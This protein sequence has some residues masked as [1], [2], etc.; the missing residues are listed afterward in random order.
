[1]SEQDVTRMTRAELND[2]AGGLGIADAAE[3][4]NKD[5]VMAAIDA[6]LAEHD[7]APDDGADDNNTDAESD[8][9]ADAAEPE[10]SGTR[11][12]VLKAVTDDDGRTYMPGEEFAPG[13]GFP[14]RRP[15]QL[16]DQKFL[17]PL[18]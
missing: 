16:V 12:E 2:Y 13:P 14:S 4:A 8:A 1:M 11:Y 17:R 7:D 9:D 3:M 10:Q 18:D 6:A 5:E 15:K